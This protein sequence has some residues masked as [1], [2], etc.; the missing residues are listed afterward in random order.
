MR[1]TGNPYWEAVKDHY[2]EM[3][4]R[5]RTIYTCQY[6]WAIPS[7]AAVDYVA[8]ASGGKIIEIGAGTGYWANQLTQ[9]GV[10]VVA[11]DLYPVDGPTENEYHRV[12]TEPEYRSPFTSLHPYFPV[13]LGGA[14]MAGVYP[15]RT[16]LLCWPPYDEPVAR[17]AL[18]SYQQAG[19]RNLIYIG[20]GKG[21]C[22]GDD[23]FHQLLKDHWMPVDRYWLPAYA[24]IYDDIYLYTR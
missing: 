9:V 8:K 21:G 10:H 17:D 4:Y 12:I 7:P 23:A 20:E 5:E 16:L 3:N 18:A 1:L 14:E 2:R 13:C 11:Y 24:R 15:D 22:T 6:A 19:G